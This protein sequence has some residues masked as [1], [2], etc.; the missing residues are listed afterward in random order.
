MK[1]IGKTYIFESEPLIIG[2]AGVAG[3]KEGEGPLG[4]DFDMVFED[5]TMGQD[6]FELAES[7]M[8]HDAIIRALASANVSPKDVDFVMTGDLLDQCTG[9]CFALKDL[10]MPFIGMYGACSTMA[11]TL[12]NSAML[13][14]AGANIC[15]AGASSHFA[16]SERQFRYPLEYGGQRP[17]TAQWTVTGAGCAVV[18]N[19]RNIEPEKLQNAVKISAVHIG[20]ITDLGIKDANNMG[21]AMAP[22]AARTIADFLHD[23]QTKPEDYDLILTGDLGLTGSKL[24]FELLQED[25]ELDIKTQHKDCGTMIFDLAEQDV[26]SGGSGCGCS[27]SVVCSHIMKNIKNGT[28]KKVLFVATGALMSPTSTKQGQS[29][30]GIAHAVLL[31]K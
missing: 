21:A 6:S 29:I 11:L 5:T 23:T 26:N 17:P 9:S 8:L 30:P 25:S 1:K 16:S 20:T 27:A 15:V 12:C 19:Q 14:S 22:A 28:L 4:A 10:E 7:A 2:S 18:Q 31:E 13:V 3:K 24:L